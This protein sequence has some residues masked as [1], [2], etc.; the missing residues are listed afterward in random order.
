MRAFFVCVILVISGFAQTGSWWTDGGVVAVRACDK[1][2]ICFGGAGV[3]IAY[4]PLTEKGV[5]LTAWHTLKQPDQGCEYGMGLKDPVWNKCEVISVVESLDIALVSVVD[6]RPL[7]Q[8]QII[9]DPTVL[10]KGEPV[11]LVGY[12]GAGWL[13]RTMKARFWY[14]SQEKGVVVETIEPVGTLE[15]LRGFSGGPMITRGRLLAIITEAGLTPSRRAVFVGPAISDILHTKP[16]PLI[17]N[18]LRP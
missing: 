13:R 15:E 8:P 6:E 9:R 14:I 3:V 7:P 5:F 11:L 2:G 16:E 10:E 4:S 18:A 17:G 12:P 1:D